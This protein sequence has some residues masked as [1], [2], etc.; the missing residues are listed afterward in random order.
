MADWYEY[1]IGGTVKAAELLNRVAEEFPDHR[2]MVKGNTVT[3]S[4]LMPH[5][6]I[7]LLLGEFPGEP[8]ELSCDPPAPYDGFRLIHPGWQAEPD[9]EQQ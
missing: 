8:W 9:G 5:E 6:V 2:P 4:N 7:Y 1:E 3:A